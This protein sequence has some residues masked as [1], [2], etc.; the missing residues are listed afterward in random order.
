M[1][2]RF[3]RFAR[4]VPEWLVYVV[5]LIPVPV[6]FYMAATNGLGFDPV[7]ALEHEFGEIAL[8]LLIIG[9]CITPLRRHFGINLLKFRRA[10]G[11]LAFIYVSLH[12]A[13][14]A[15][16]DVQTL[17]RVWADILKRPYITVGMAAFLLMLPL[18]VTSNNWS[19]RKLGP[20][21]RRLHMAVY[22][23]APLGALHFIWVRKGFQWEPII[24]GA[25]ILGL[26]ALRLRKPARQNKIL[27]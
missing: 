21:W 5:Y 3:N 11:L 10:I 23:I 14:W 13:V 9:L 20:L 2:D 12:L 16:L 25:V 6:L 17:E 19:V 27:A 8:Q 24:Y 7:E 15:V 18:A 4:R 26:I 22:L 1:K